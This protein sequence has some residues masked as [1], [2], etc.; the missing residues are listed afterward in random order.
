MKKFALAIA[1][2]ALAFAIATPVHAQTG[3]VAVPSAT[4]STTPLVSL[5]WQTG[6]ATGTQVQCSATFQCDYAIYR[7]AGTCPTQ[8]TGV[9]AWT[10]VGTT[11]ANVLAY[12]DT[13]VAAS[14]QYSYVVEAIAVTGGA[15]SDPSNCT[16]VTTKANPQV[17]APPVVT[18]S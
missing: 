15:N 8:I 7:I 16:T 9:T 6:T 13:T 12:K 5:T 18:G 11:A 14:T 1:S 17:P 10:A 4:A 3:L 2:L